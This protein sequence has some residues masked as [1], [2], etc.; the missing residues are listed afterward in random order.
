MRDKHSAPRLQVWISAYGEDALERVA[1]LPHPETEGVEYA[2]CWQK[3]D[4]SRIPA[5]IKERPDFKIVFEDSEGLSHNRNAALRNSDADLMLIS[6]DDLEYDAEH[7]ENIFKGIEDYPDYDFYV[8]RF[9]SPDSPKTYHESSFDISKAPKGYYP[10]S[11]ELLINMKRIGRDLDELMPLFNPHFGVNGATFHSGEE[12]LLV[13]KLLKRGYKGRYVPL[14]ITVHSGSSTGQRC[15][16]Q[17]SHIETKGACFLY[18]HPATWALRMLTHAWRSARG[19]EG[20]VSFFSYCRHWC[21]GVRKAAKRKVF[22][23]Y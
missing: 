15:R 22:K 2:V 8:F 19:K 11:V 10:S 1:S 9:R 23:G 7:F 5:E 18:L 3:Y 12:N 20:K 21:R 17:A 16:H 6:D 13:A 4:K 14:E